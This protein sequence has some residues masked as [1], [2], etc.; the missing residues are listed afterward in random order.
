MFN[1]ILRATS[2]TVFPISTDFGVRRSPEWN[3]FN[4]IEKIFD[5]RELNLD[6]VIRSIV[7]GGFDLKRRLHRQLPGK[8]LMNGDIP[9]G[10][11]PCTFFHDGKGCLRIQMSSKNHQ[12]IRR[13]DPAAQ[14]AND[15]AGNAPGIIPACVRDNSADNRTGWVRQYS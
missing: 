1:P 5:K 13:R 3:N 9:E 14:Q 10:G 8:G 15:I 4:V 6:G 11:F 12:G 2:T 7:I